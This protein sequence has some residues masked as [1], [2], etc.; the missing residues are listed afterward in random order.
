MSSAGGFSGCSG[1][2]HGIGSGSATNTN[3]G[4]F[5]DHTPSASPT[6]FGSFLQPPTE[7]VQG[8]FGPA[9]S[10]HTARSSAESSS[11]YLGAIDGSVGSVTE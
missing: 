2:G 8:E 10:P 1:R 3:S 9:D 6:H 7:F 11:V 5:A 4:S